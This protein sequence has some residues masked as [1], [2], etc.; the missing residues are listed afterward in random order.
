MASEK[1]IPTEYAERALKERRAARGS[2]VAK[3]GIFQSPKMCGVSVCKG[4]G[5]CSE[6][7]PPLQH[8]QDHVDVLPQAGVGR[9]NRN[10]QKRL[11]EVDPFLKVGDGALKSGN[12]AGKIMITLRHWISFLLNRRP[13]Q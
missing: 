11:Q 2:L 13:S 5:G 3:T 6:R 8:Q 7:M 10:I 4:F 12:S 1:Y 9:S